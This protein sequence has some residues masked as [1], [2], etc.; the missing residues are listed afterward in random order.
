[1]NERERQMLELYGQLSRRVVAG[2]SDESA[3]DLASEALL[4]ALEQPAPDGRLAPWAERILG[5]LLV[6]AWRRR[7]RAE[8]GILRCLATSGEGPP[9]PED[10]ALALERRR[11]LMRNLS[12]APEDLREALRL[13]FFEELPFA[14]VAARSGVPPE[15]ARTRV[16]RALGW[17]RARLQGLQAL[18]PCGS[19]ASGSVVAAVFALAA[20]G[21][22]PL[23][24]EP[25]VETA[26]PGPSLPSGRPVPS[27]VPATPLPVRRGTPAAER[28][29]PA[30]ALRPAQPS[31][32]EAGAA[33]TP[34]PAA[35]PAPA[36]AREPLSSRSR[37]RSRR[38]SSG[39]SKICEASAASPG[40]ASRARRELLG[41]RKCVR[42]RR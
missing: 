36:E 21:S 26:R 7:T 39:H 8:R 31:S 10:E 15:T 35:S 14:I 23:G 5:N 4:R 37:A 13:R 38:R 20:V 42:P 17:L 11:A 28:S 9:S 40:G 30:D 32:K 29:T 34:R 24:L 12:Q 19:A 16:H 41:S 18:L 2:R 33:R 6:D 27:V 22:G 1:M 3:A 25:T